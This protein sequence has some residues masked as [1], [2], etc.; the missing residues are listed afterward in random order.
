MNKRATLV[1]GTM[2]VLTA[3]LASADSH[4][5]EP[6]KGMDHSAMEGAVGEMMGAMDA[7]MQAMPTESA[8]MVD[9]DFL[10]IMIP[11]HQSAIDMARIEL[12]QGE[13]EET[14]AMAQ[15]IID[16]QEAAI[17]EMRAMLERMG[18]EAPAAPAE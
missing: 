9:A 4:E 6:M 2:L 1:T 11:H 18:V 5:A 3:G 16:A 15:E 14:R 8:G 13:D 7:M 10:L 12:E 17:E